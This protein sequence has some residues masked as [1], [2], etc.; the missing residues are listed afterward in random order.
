MGGDFA[1]ILQDYGCLEDE[2]AKFYI[3]E[4]VLALEYLHSLG[5]IHR[6]LKP[7]NL[8]LDHQGHIKLTDFGLSEPGVQQK[9]I[10]A[11]SATEE[12]SNLIENL[13][14]KL[15]EIEIERSIVYNEKYTS[16]TALDKGPSLTRL[17]RGPSLTKLDKGPS[18]TRLDKGPSLTRL[19]KGPS[20]TRLDNGQSLTR[21]DKRP[22]LQKIDKGPSL[23]K[24]DKSASN[25]ADRSMRKESIFFDEEE[26][27]KRQA[28]KSAKKGPNRLVGTPDYMAPEIIK[29]ISI[30]HKSL[31][32]WSLGV[33]IF[34][35]LTGFP[36]FN[37]DSVEKI[38]DNILNLRIPWDQLPEG[39]TSLYDFS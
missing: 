18:L 21:L 25:Q 23:T 12:S 5:I 33:M 1:H 16:L 20:L 28:E 7:D 15:P 9:L 26:S 36:P 19:D 17:D 31:D 11:N 27:E 39:I 8:L 3:A 14:E 30:S 32:W 4:I 38:Y 6:D 24:L 13:M 10:Q 34:E 2:V 37:D 22:S 29:G 35:F